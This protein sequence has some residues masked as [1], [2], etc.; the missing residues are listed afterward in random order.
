MSN[1]TYFNSSN[2]VSNDNIDNIAFA[3]FS[4]LTFCSILSDS[5]IVINEA[6]SNTYIK[7]KFNR[8]KNFTDVVMGLSFHKYKNDKEGNIIIDNTNNT[9]HKKSSSTNP[10][11]D[12]DN[13]H[14]N[15]INNLPTDLSDNQNEVQNN[16]TEETNNNEVSNNITENLNNNEI[17]SDITENLNNNEIQS[18]I[19][20][21]SNNNE[22]KNEII[23]I[24]NEENDEIDEDDDN[25][26]IELL[27][28]INSDTII[29]HNKEID[30]DSLPEKPKKKKT[31]KGL[32]KKIKSDKT[33][34]KDTKKYKEKI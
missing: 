15:I 22:N 25:D 16:I 19:T 23:N 24:K 1:S 11:D 29:L 5:Y 31:K 3:F 20:K 18:D 27:N 4:L 17:P 13:L 26:E 8:F 12:I 34:V 32:D 9:N 33:I 30:F 10:F 28:I 7:K 2:I 6:F 21:K 14:D